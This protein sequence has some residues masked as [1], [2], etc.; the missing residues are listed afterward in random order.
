MGILAAVLLVGFSPRS[1]A[2]G[3]TRLTSL[4]KKAIATIVLGREIV[5][6]QTGKETTVLVSP[7]MEADWLPEIPGIRFRRLAYGEQKS[8]REFIKL[9]FEEHR[10]YVDAHFEKG[11]Y[12]KTSGTAYRFRRESGVWRGAATGPSSSTLGD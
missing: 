1:T 11:N 2:S 9:W 7:G 8:V 10:R 3:P 6:P 12:C 4:D 5:V